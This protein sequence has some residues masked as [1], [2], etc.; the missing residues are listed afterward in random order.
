MEKYIY[1]GLGI[2][3]GIAIALYVY[4][5]KKEIYAKKI[6]NDQDLF[7]TKKLDSA[8]EKAVKE[9]QSQMKFQ[10]RKLTEDEKNIIIFGY[11]KESEN[12][13]Q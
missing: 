1:L 7:S 8:L 9:M 3:L 10:G 12:I 5:I 13:K 2:V 11:L 4:A 6:K